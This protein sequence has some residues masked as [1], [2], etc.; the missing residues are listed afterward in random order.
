[1]RSLRDSLG[2][3]IMFISLV[4]AVLG[5]VIVFSATA[6]MC[7]STPD[8]R[9]DPMFFFKRQGIFMFVGLFAMWAVRKVDLLRWR[10]LLSLPTMVVTLALLVL[11]MLVGVEINGAR[12]WFII[13][14][15]QIQIAEFAKLAVIFYLADCLARH[16]DRLDP[17][18]SIW[19]V[20]LLV[21]GAVILI[22]QEP[23][24]GTSMVV[25]ATILGMLYAAG[26]RVKHLAVGVGLGALAVIFL[27]AQKAYRVKRLLVFLDPF[28]DTQDAGYQIYN[29][30]LAVASGGIWGRGIGFSHQKFNYLPEGHTDFVFAIMAEEIG[31]V[32]C[33]GV[34]GLF[35]LLC[36]CGFK[37]AVNCRRPYL[38]LLA[39]GITFGIVFQAL[40]NVAVVTGSV[41]STGIPLPFISY[42]G[43]SLVVTLISI[44]ILLNI[45]DY[46]SRQ[47]VAAPEERKESRRM[48]RGST[49]S[50]SEQED[51]VTVSS[52]EWES[53]VGSARP[54]KPRTNLPHPVVEP[55]LTKRVPFQPGSRAERERLRRRQAREVSGELRR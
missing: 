55:H 40:L 33:V 24:L 15:V 27:I 17:L 23:D 49:L 46:T 6:A 22:E 21:G 11:V 51:V 26:A 12:R 25:A 8:F 29:S 10:S 35:A 31:F 2:R 18:W 43:S 1:M 42:G 37:L 14:P 36:L 44:G 38:S 48:R 47:M 13:G 32:G 34:I 52:G 54:E 45:S 9:H 19:P 50:T 28:S 41:P 20:L 16:R 39:L 53:A 5:V 7:A 30:L 3:P 4:L